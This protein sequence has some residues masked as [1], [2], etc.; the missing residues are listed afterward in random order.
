MK[1]AILIN[2]IGPHNVGVV[3]GSD[4]AGFP[5]EAFQGRGVFHLGIG[6]HLDGHP[7]THQAMLAQVDTAHATG[8]K[9]FQ[10]L[11]FADVEATPLA[12]QYLLGLK[13]GQQTV[14]DQHAGHLGLVRWDAVGRLQLL[15]KG[16]EAFL[17]GHPAL[18]HEVQELVNAHWRWHGHLSRSAVILESAHT[19][20]PEIWATGATSLR[21][22]SRSALQ[23][24]G[25][26]CV[27][28]PD[29]PQ[30]SPYSRSQNMSLPANRLFRKSL[31]LTF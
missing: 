20:L 11:V 24:K 6:Q 19:T 28:P 2:V 16:V 1:V 3:Q 17:I 26:W 12:L 14:L 7:P 15:Q 30:P 31:M 10:H 29:W 8:P 4:G 5:M 9:A 18:A 27:R 21:S 13:V 22:T 23:G 25:Y